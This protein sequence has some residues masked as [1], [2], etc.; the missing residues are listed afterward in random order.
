M[1]AILLEPPLTEE[2]RREAFRVLVEAQDQGL[3]VRHSRQI[4]TRRFGLSVG[5]M[6]SLEEE[7][8]EAGWPPLSPSED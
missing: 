4:V 7:G 2:I 5:Q 8:V 6:L 1:R 3:P